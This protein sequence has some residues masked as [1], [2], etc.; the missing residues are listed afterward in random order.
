MN[1]TPQRIFDALYKVLSGEDIF[2]S[3][4]R[5]DGGKYARNLFMKLTDKKEGFS[6]F[7]DELGTEPG[8]KIP[9]SL[10][11]KVRNSSTLVLIGSPCSTAST[12]MGDEIDEFLSVQRNRESTIPIDVGG[13]VRNADWHKNIAG[14]DI[15]DEIEPDAL[16][17]GKVSDS[18]IDRIRTAAK[19]RKR[20]D[21][22]RLARN[23]MLA[24]LMFLL[25]LS[26]AA[27]WFAERKIRAATD[28][29]E[30]AAKS[31][32]MAKKAQED[33][34]AVIADAGTK[35]KTA[36]GLVTEAQKDAETAITDA[37]RRIEH[38]NDLVSAADNKRI[39]AENKEKDARIK[40][41]A[42]EKQSKVQEAIAEARRLA[43]QSTESINK[44][45]ANIGKAVGYA[46]DSAQTA[47]SQQVRLFEATK[48]LRDSLS[49]MPLRRDARAVPTMD[50]AEA[51]VFTPDARHIALLK[52]VKGRAGKVIHIFPVVELPNDQ[53]QVLAPKHEFI[54]EGEG[55]ISHIA[56]SDGFR[57]AAALKEGLSE[58]VLLVKDVEGKT[59]FDSTKVQYY[60]NKLRVTGVALSPDGKLLAMCGVDESG[61]KSIY[62]VLIGDLDKKI[63]REIYANQY[64]TLKNVTFGG[65]GK[66][67]L[68]VGGSPSG[69]KFL[70][71]KSVLLWQFYG[72]DL[73]KLVEETGNLIPED[74]YF[75]QGLENV[76]ISD[77]GNLIAVSSWYESVSVWQ[78]DSLSSEPKLREIARVAPEVGGDQVR[79]SSDGKTLNVLSRRFFSSWDSAGYTF[80]LEARTWDQNL[81]RLFP[82]AL[83]NSLASGQNGLVVTEALTSKSYKVVTEARLPGPPALFSSFTSDSKT[84]V[85]LAVKPDGAQ[86]IHIY[87]LENNEYVDRRTIPLGQRATELIWKR[88]VDVTI[89]PEGETYEQIAI[90]PKGNYVAVRCA[91]SVKNKRGLC[92]WDVSSGTWLTRVV[93]HGSAN[94]SF[95]FSADESSLGSFTREKEFQILSLVDESTRIVPLK[96]GVV[97]IALDAQGKFIAL[98]TILNEIAIWDR[99]NFDPV[100]VLYP[101]TLFPEV[102]FSLDGKR[103]LTK[104]YDRNSDKRPFYQV[105]ELDNN[106]LISKGCERL[107][108]NAFVDPS[109][110]CPN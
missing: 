51:Y 64:T 80:A 29:E 30:R 86:E 38:A 37:N 52:S 11:R 5:R 25:M 102:V 106:D 45:A 19:Y 84:L 23:W 108:R 75:P 21:R 73:S 77:D 34:D 72:K 101:T 88:P 68:A 10:R 8:Q 67:L 43:N 79:L 31:D 6:C 66:I 26:G 15:E 41:E 22:L 91:A 69:D 95:V 14:V 109:Q 94:I 90:S 50:E 40:A 85:V 71:N 28:A 36:N 65:Q 44:S 56:V 32:L 2:I 3:Y 54:F 49:L 60:K 99:K 100:M 39:E 83:S 16:T 92:V 13:V 104:G 107:K 9:S 61:P 74:L 58:P 55:H 97:R 46:I 48:A 12:A 105:W 59:V 70:S 62:K 18:V 35:I 20:N 33:A 63:F 17:T 81:E 82:G 76:A 93:E 1:L 110:I 47:G 53:E 103:L 27:G 42:A 24:L 87:Q 89:E 98:V 78:L 7:I 57:R 96:D 4:A